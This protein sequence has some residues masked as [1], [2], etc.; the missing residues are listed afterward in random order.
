VQDIPG[1]IE[2]FG[3]KEKFIA[4]LD[5]NFDSAH[6][7]HDNEPGHHYLYLY[8]YA[9]QPWKAQELARKHTTINY[10]NLPNGINGND[11][12]GQ[13]SA[14][15]IFSVMG[16]YPVTPG[17]GIYAIG[18]P[19]FPKITIDYLVEGKQHQLVIIANNISDKN[20]YI[21]SLTLDGKAVDKPFLSHD[22]I[23]HGEKLIFEMTDEPTAWGK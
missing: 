9:G 15:Y 18:A 22:D 13:M 7:R 2:L 5:E 17:S 4:R 8:N 21:R 1:T 16:F 19:Q 10:R 23:I 20:K 12:C 11:D 14:W 6:Y 3:G